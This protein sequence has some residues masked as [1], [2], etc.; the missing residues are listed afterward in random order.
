MNWIQRIIR[1]RFHPYGLFNLFSNHPEIQPI[2]CRYRP[3]GLFQYGAN[4]FDCK[5]DVFYRGHLAE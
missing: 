2:L 3:T 4:R 1:L 5:I